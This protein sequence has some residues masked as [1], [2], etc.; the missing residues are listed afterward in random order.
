MNRQKFLSAVL[1]VCL[2]CRLYA[3]RSASAPN[4]ENLPQGVYIRELVSDTL[5]YENNAAERYYRQH[6][7]TA[8]SAYRHGL[9]GAGRKNHRRAKSTPS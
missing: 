3:K 8:D 4:I 7:E 9:F 2:F 6:P 5:V 1:V